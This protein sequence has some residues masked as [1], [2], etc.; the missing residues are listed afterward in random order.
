MIAKYLSIGKL[1]LSQCKKLYSL[2]IFCN[3]L[4]AIC[5]VL[6]PIV[7][8]IM[9]STLK[10][11][12]STNAFRLLLYF[13][14]PLKITCV[15]V[16][17][18]VVKILVSLLSGIV[19]RAFQNNLTTKIKYTLHRKFLS[20]D[21]DYH[22]KHDSGEVIFNMENSV[23]IV[24]AISLLFI[25]P[26]STIIGLVIG[27][28]GVTTSL[29]SVQMPIWLILCIIVALFF[30]PFVSY[31]MGQKINKSFEFLRNNNMA[32]YTEMLNSLKNPIEVQILAAEKQ[33]DKSILAALTN[34]EK[35]SNRANV[36]ATLHS[37]LSP[38]C[39]LLFQT[40]IAVFVTVLYL[41][42]AKMAVAGA[43]TTCILLIPTIF[44]QISTFAVTYIQ[45]KQTE[46]DVRALYDLLQLEPG[47]KNDANA[48]DYDNLKKDDIVVDDLRFGYNEKMILQNL[49]LKI[50]S[51]KMIAIVSHSGGGKSTLLHLFS[52]LYDPQRGCIAIGGKDIKEYTIAS[53]R[54]AIV[55]VSQFPLFIQG[56]LRENFQLQKADAT[57]NEI[58]ETCRKVG[59]WDVIKEQH[60]GENPVDLQLSLGAENF[61]GGQ[62][63]LLA[64]ARAMLKD[65]AVLLLDEPT[66]GVDA[67]TTQ[68]KIY[69]FL[70]EYKKKCSIIFVDHNMNFVRNLADMVLVLEDGKVADF[71]PTEEVWQ[72]KDSL[73]RKLWE[74]YNKN[75]EFSNELDN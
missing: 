53:L 41:N 58:E 67:Q 15:F 54:S 52:R 66:T 45:A 7:L 70:M 14:T 72:K 2:L 57:D 51:E 65:P 33:R 34:V 31:W 23:G 60:L 4:S 36:L 13:D 35:A 38:V 47:V 64:I 12:T 49:S 75:T 30:Y 21:A 56:S 3:I 26:I 27:L 24:G 50:P 61:S 55:R 48:T 71:G 43:L 39:I 40:M 68:D 42:N 59:V 29:A 5:D 11:E 8:G 6:I 19:E 25:Q 10:G 73:F 9:I 28:S 1:F 69:P 16:T 17:I 32:L 46:P 22:N 37:Q 63:R 74:E 44:N 18:S 62:R 20:L